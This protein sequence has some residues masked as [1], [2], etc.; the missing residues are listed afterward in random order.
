MRLLP[1]IFNYYT[2]DLFPKSTAS[3]HNRRGTVAGRLV[4]GPNIVFLSGDRWKK[5]RKVNC[6]LIFFL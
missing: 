4:T 6:Y 2:E 1:V 3:V 5:Q